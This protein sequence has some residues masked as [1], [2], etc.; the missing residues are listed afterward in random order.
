MTPDAHCSENREGLEAL[1]AL[2]DCIPP[3]GGELCLDPGVTPQVCFVP[4]QASSAPFL[5]LSAHVLD[6]ELPNV[7][8]LS[9]AVLLV[10]LCRCVQSDPAF[11]PP[12]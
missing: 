10:S 1:L 7:C 4:L 12:L 9:S 3:A 2:L 6:L 5:C 11:L 8:T